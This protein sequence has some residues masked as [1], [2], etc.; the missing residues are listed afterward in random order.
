MPGEVGHFGPVLEIPN[1][2]VRIA[3]AR[4][5]N[6]AVRMELSA[7]QTG[8]GSVTDFDDH[9]ARFD[10][11]KR[12]VSVGRARQQVIAG[13]VERETRDGSFVS[14]DDLQGL[15]GGHVPRPHRRVRRCREDEFLRRVEDGVCDTLRV[16]LEQRH[17]LKD[18]GG[19]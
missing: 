12:P 9:V 18:K 19:G 8:T 17:H 3:G 4:A 5:E 14:A 7:R 11:G 1:A 2:N 16:T 13:R 6:Q 15:R 10:V